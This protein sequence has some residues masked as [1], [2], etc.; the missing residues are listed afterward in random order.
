[1]TISKLFSDPVNLTTKLKTKKEKYWKKRGE[2]MALGLFRSM[3]ERVP[4]YKDFLKKQKVDSDKIKSIQDFEFVPTISKDNYLRQ[5]SLDQLSWDGVFPKGQWDISS[6]S[7]STGEPFYFPRTEEQNLQYA[8][9]AELYLRTNFAI[10]KKNTLYINCFALGVWI[11]GLFT[12]E[13]LKLLVKRGKYNLT[14][15]NP[16]LNKTEI[17]KVVRKLGPL[18]DQVIIG[19]Y[20]PFVKDVIDDG[21]GSGIEW[22]KYNIKFV[23]SAEVF[24]ENFRDYLFEKAGQ[25]NI[26]L[27]SLNHYGTVDQGTLAHETPLSIMVRREAINN[28]ELFKRIFGQEVNRLPTLAQYLPELF[29]FEEVDNGLVCS[30]YSGLPLVRYD[31]KDSGGIVGYEEAEKIFGENMLDLSVL[32]KN[33]S[34]DNTIY[35]LPFVF[36]YERKDLSVSFCGA[37]IYPETIR[38]VLSEVDFVS[39][40]TGKFVL[41]VN[42]DEKQDPYL[43]INIE[44]KNGFSD[45]GSNIVKRLLENIVSR[46]LSENSEYGSVYHDQKKEKAVPHLKF[47][48]YESPEYFKVGGKQKWVMKN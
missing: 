48:L 43:E 29:Y 15:I 39:H 44:M 3:A 36:V 42:R 9:L 47:C 21:V 17:L 45:P 33:N 4:A 18:F 27:D 23:F 12:Y 40:F 13:A 8:L 25:D 2:K 1:M 6:T 41:M 26:F 11:G 19:G 10:H 34:I 31:L 30:S 16:G 35:N 38:R 7:G 28:E 20:P 14:L 32:S 5:Y 46:L 37:N 24:S 22:S